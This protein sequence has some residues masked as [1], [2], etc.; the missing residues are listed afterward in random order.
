MKNS[1]DGVLG[2][3]NQGAAG[4]KAQSTTRIVL[5][6]IFPQVLSTRKRK[7]AAESEIKVQV[8]VFAFDLLYLNGE[9]LVTKSLAERREL[10]RVSFSL[11]CDA[12]NWDFPSDTFGQSSV[13]HLTTLLGTKT[14]TDCPK[15]KH[16]RRLT[17]KSA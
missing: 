15:M 8:A 7:D 2:N 13:D 9:P 11:N 5:D 1:L 6:H 3:G 16:S 14:V 12:I 17:F 10:L 4:C